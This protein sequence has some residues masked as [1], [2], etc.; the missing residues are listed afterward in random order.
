MNKAIAGFSESAAIPSAPLADSP[1][2]ALIFLSRFAGA[3]FPFTSGA[4]V[5]PPFQNFSD[6][7]SA[8]P[9][10]NFFFS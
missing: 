6:R 5:V 1:V 7:R 9:L 3:F 4:I 10:V 2:A 8:R